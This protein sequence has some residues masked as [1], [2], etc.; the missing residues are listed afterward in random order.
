[1]ARSFH[2]AM[3]IVRYFAKPS[4]FI[5][6]TAYSRWEKIADELLPGQTTRDHPDLVARVIHIRVKEFVHEII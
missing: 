2:N 3:V 1:M 6:F 4:L 5:T